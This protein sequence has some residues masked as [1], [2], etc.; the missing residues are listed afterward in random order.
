MKGRT[1]IP[2]SLHFIALLTAAYS[3]T[4]YA[5]PKQE[6]WIGKLRGD[7]VILPL[8]RKEGST[9]ATLSLADKLPS[10][11]VT[12]S[13]DG[14]RQEFENLKPTE[15]DTHCDVWPGLPT[16]K[17]SKKRSR[18]SGIT[19]GVAS[20]GNINAIPFLKVPE[21]DPKMGEIVKLARPH[22]T[23]IQNRTFVP[24][25]LYCATIDQS[26]KLCTYQFEMQ[27][28]KENGCFATQVQIGWVKVQ[29]DLYKVL[30]KKLLDTDCDYQ[31]I[32][33]V[34]PIGIVID[35]NKVQV[36]IE[37]EGYE[38]STYRILLFKGSQLKQI[39]TMGRGSC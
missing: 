15:V 36:L 35:N 28:P 20:S 38:D 13:R 11:W 22:F 10:K 19:L 7:D 39:A 23:A 34:S 17:P 16:A 24:T 8:F 33:T 27:G 14:K 25:S 6:A 3:L 4:A 21:T 12:A 5:A 26:K 1:Q 32:A 9:W 18:K 2:P 29:N 30:E 31:R 37:D